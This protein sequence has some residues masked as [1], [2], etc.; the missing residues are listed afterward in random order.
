M[1][2]SDTPIFGIQAVKE[3]PRKVLI[4]GARS[5]QVTISD[6]KSGLLLRLLREP[7]NINTVNIFLYH[8]NK[9]YSGTN[10]SD[11]NIF[12]FHVSNNSIV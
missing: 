6:A 11:I 8:N 5:K 4:V 3:G 12:N 9:I 10:G 7:E 2:F 1:D